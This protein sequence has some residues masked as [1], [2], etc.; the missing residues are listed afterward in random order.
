MSLNKGKVSGRWRLSKGSLWQ[1][2]TAQ[3]GF[4]PCFR[5][6]FAACCYRGTFSS[7]SVGGEG[8]ISADHSSECAGGCPRVV[9]HC[10]GSP[11]M[12]GE[13]RELQNQGKTPSLGA[14][15]S[16]PEDTVIPSLGALSSPPWGHCRPLPGGTVIHTGAKNHPDSSQQKRDEM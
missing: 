7:G 2:L 13:E 11:A 12:R 9:Q 8:I 1:E 10:R 16:L 4:Y 15:S 14:L 5:A 6:V 3:G